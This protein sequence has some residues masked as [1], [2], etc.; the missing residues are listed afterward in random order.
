M[1]IIGG[2][3]NAIYNPRGLIVLGVTTKLIGVSSVA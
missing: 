3:M 2:Y 1:K